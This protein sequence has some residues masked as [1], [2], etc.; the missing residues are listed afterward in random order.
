MNH[1]AS[2]GDNNITWTNAKK[3]YGQKYIH[4]HTWIYINGA[5]LSK[6]GGEKTPSHYDEQ[7]EILR[8]PSLGLNAKRSKQAGTLKTLAK[9][10]KKP[11]TTF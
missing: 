10:K 9:T 2:L 6:N 8:T 4:T 11:N 3:K 7:R 5:L 1:T